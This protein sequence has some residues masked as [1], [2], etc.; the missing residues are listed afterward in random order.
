M[1]KDT[2]TES[3]TDLPYYTAVRWLVRWVFKLRKE[4]GDLLESKGKPQALMS[5][6]AWVWKLAFAADITSH[7]NFLNLKL[8]G[9]ENLVSDL[10]THLKAFRYNLSCFWNKYRPTTWHTFSSADSSWLK[11]QMIS[12][13]HLHARSSKTSSCSFRSGFLTWIQ[14]Q[15]KWYCFKTHLKQMWP[16]AQM[17]CIWRSLSRKQIT[18]LIQ[19]K[20]GLVGFYQFL[21]KEDF[22]NVK[23][24]ASSYLLIFGT[25]YLCEQTFLRM[26][27]VKEQFEK[28]LVR[29]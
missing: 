29:W 22:P 9:E 5:D 6:E 24:F 28:K 10:Y 15:K 14:R 3:N 23:T 27:Y 18:S 1:F 12:P 4:I 17:N 20:E 2:D 7:L 26:K 16:V 19:F 25:T 8:Q 21:S 11:Q 13:S